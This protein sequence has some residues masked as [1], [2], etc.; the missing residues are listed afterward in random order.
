M[1]SETW[2]T[3]SAKVAPGRL[4]PA[5]GVRLIHLFFGPKATQ[6]SHGGLDRPADRA[7]SQRKT[8]CSRHVLRRSAY[9]RSRVGCLRTAPMF[10]TTIARHNFDNRREFFKIERRAS[11][12]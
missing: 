12:K 4:E 2:H 3:C 11:D 1:S 6:P 10:R 5:V 9:L 7:A 8:L